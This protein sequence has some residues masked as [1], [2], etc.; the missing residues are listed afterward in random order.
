M[1]KVPE[2]YR[3]VD[4]P[5][6]STIKDGNNGCFVLAKKMSGLCYRRKLQIIAS[7]GLGWEHVSCTIVKGKFTYIPSWD[8]MC[9]VKSLFWDDEDV[10]VQYH[11]AKKDYINMHKNV[12]HLWRPIGVEMPTPPSILLGF[13]D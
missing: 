5:M 8:D 2:K 11:P 10:V 1:F 7:D 6:A 12:L 13:K 3:V 4:G 9:F